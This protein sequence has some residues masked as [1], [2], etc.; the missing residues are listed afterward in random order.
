VHMQVSEAV[1]EAA[2]KSGAARLD[3]APS[4]L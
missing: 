3:R 1:R 2:V 4:G